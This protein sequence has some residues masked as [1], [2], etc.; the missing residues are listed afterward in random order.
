[1]HRLLIIILEPQLAAL[2]PPSNTLMCL[3]K[4]VHI[5]LSTYVTCEKEK[6]DTNLGHD[7][8]K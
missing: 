3:G 6:Q 2:E 7:R 8:P 5:T 1:M 4:I